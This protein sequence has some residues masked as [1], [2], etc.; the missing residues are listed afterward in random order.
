MIVSMLCST[1]ANVHTYP[2][3]ESANSSHD[4]PF[5]LHVWPVDASRRQDHEV[6]S[7]LEI[8]VLLSLWML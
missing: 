1:P 2:L 5:A 4:E 7:L 8:L 3:H 6:L